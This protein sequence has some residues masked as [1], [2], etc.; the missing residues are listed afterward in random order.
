MALSKAMTK[1]RRP[2]GGFRV[3]KVLILDISRAHFHL[4]AKRKLFIRIPEEDGGG[5]GLLL[6]TM[7]CARDAAA[8]WGEYHREK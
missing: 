6:R 5:L 8:G 7:Y 2:S 4:L 1:A 3:K